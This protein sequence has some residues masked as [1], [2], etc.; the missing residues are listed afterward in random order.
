[1]HIN[2]AIHELD[3]TEDIATL[4]SFYQIEKLDKQ[5]LYKIKPYRKDVYSYYKK[6]FELINNKKKIIKRY[7]K[8]WYDNNWTSANKFK[9]ERD[10]EIWEMILFFEV[11]LIHNRKKKE[12]ILKVFTPQKKT[13]TRITDSDIEKAKQVP[14]ESLHEFTYRN[15]S[16]CLWH[17]EDTPSLHLYKDSNTAHCFGSCGK[18]YDS[19]EFY[20]KIHNCDFITAVKELSS[21]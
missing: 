10:I 17:S 18:T 20:K 9:K 7:I 16:C 15:K 11:D 8:D 19:I 4:L 3:C 2:K 13:K 6:Y 14:I 12:D 1:M 5:S 21:Y